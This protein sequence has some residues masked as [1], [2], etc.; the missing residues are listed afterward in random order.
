MVKVN[1][2]PGSTADA[3]NAAGMGSR[4]NH[5]SEGRMSLVF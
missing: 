4:D 2:A 1:S 5:R 3:R